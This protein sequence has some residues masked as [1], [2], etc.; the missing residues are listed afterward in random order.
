MH[1][2]RKQCFGP[3]VK[4]LYYEIGRWKT[5]LVPEKILCFP[6][7]IFS[8]VSYSTEQNHYQELNEPSQTSRPR[9]P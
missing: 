5:V 1:R 8:D 9:Y 2:N 4:K 6:L 3:A 7:V